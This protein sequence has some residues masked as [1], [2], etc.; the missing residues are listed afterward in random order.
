MVHVVYMYVCT[1][2]HVHEMIYK[3]TISTCWKKSLLLLLLLLYI[4]H[5]LYIYV[6][7]I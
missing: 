7:Y 1:H 4:I 5:I 3:A 2:V 6:I